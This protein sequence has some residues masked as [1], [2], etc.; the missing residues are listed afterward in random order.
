MYITIYLQVLIVAGGRESGNKYTP[1]SST[2]K[3]T[4]GATAWTSIRHLP[5]TLAFV[6]S[7]S[8]GNKIFLA[9]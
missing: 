3:L 4:T 1:L 6:A 2:E 7:V 5:R 8:I 9:G